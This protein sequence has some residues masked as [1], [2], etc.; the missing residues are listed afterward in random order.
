MTF[1]MLLMCFEDLPQ[2]AGGHLVKPVS[3]LGLESLMNEC[4][5]QC[6]W[7]SLMSD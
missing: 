7:M 3:P 5:N 2:S 6:R 4:K 1:C